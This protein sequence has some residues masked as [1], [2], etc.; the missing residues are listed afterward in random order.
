MK[1][2]FVLI[3]CSI[4]TLPALAQEDQ[5]L[6]G[7]HV[8][9]GG[10]GG[11]VLKIS[12]ISGEAGLLV[13]GRGGWIIKL[14][15]STSFVIG[16]GVYGLA[17][18]VKANNVFINNHQQYVSFGYGGVEL[19]YVHQSYK[20]VHFSIQ[21]LIGAGGVAYQNRDRE[22]QTDND[23]FFVCEPGANVMVNVSHFFRIGAGVG[24]RLTSGSHLLEASD[25]NLS[26]VMGIITFKFGK[27]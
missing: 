20:L 25:S 22:K 13:G 1:Q 23:S 8:T 12:S 16:G 15:P 10:F 3:L 17:S 7:N 5:T 18:D 4:T 9:S 26:G 2:L 27:F 11:P 21:T 19:E 14:N 6:V 24:Y